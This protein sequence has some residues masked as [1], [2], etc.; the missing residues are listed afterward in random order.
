MFSEDSKYT[1]CYDSKMELEEDLK[2]EEEK[3]KEQELRQRL[4]TS[5]YG[6]INQ[7]ELAQEKVKHLR[8][9]RRLNRKK[10]MT[11]IVYQMDNFFSSV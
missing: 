6:N 5:L 1:W 2:S 10:K 3:A 8:L 11:K 4:V 9:E 7:E